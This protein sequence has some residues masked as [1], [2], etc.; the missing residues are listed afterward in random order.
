MEISIEPGPYGTYILYNVGNERETI[1]IQSDYDFPG[2]A[3]AFGFV[4]CRCGATDGTI[5][6][7]HKTAS[8][9]I[10]AARD[11]LDNNEGKIVDD[12]GYFDS[13]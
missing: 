6:C 10:S 3:S 8:A 7:P 5:D 9:M 1:L 11:W 2:V 4:P 12:P 13:H